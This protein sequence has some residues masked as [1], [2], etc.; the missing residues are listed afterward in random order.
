M[1]NKTYKLSDKHITY[2]HKLKDYLLSKG[3]I[4]EVQW[5]RPTPPPTHCTIYCPIEKIDRMLKEGTYN[6][7][8]KDEMNGL[9]EFYLLASINVDKSS[10]YESQ[11]SSSFGIPLVD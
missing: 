11:Y 7:T 3:Y 2:L 5:I 9:R 10:Y 1:P 8:D 6:E 4:D